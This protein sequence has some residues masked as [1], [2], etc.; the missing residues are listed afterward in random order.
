MN[1]CFGKEMASDLLQYHFI[2][3]SARSTIGLSRLLCGGTSI[4]FQPVRLRPILCPGES[5]STGMAVGSVLA[6]FTAWS[7]G[8][9]TNLRATFVR[10][11]S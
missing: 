11:G 3:D 2:Q 1:Y 6:V 8:S 4:L 10:R 9:L 7:C 5:A